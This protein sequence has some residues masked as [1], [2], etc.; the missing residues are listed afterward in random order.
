MDLSNPRKTLVRACSVVIA[1]GF[2]ASTLPLPAAAAPLDGA[3]GPMAALQDPT[4]DGPGAGEHGE[5]TTSY[6]P[7]LDESTDRIIVKFEDDAAP[8]QRDAVVAEVAADDGVSAESLEPL[9]ETVGGALVLEADQML[10]ETELE[11]TIEALEADPA[12][13]YAEPDYIINA[14]QAATPRNPPNDPYY[15]GYQWN[16]RAI[17]AAGA[18]RYATGEGGGIGI[19]DT[20]Q[21][22]H[23]ELSGKTL[24]GYDF[25]SAGQSR[26]S[27]G[28]NPNPNDEGDW[29]PQVPTSMW[30][31]THVAVI[32]AA[33]TDNGTGVAGVAPTREC[34]TL[35]LWVLMVGLIPLIRQPVLPGAPVCQCPVL[36]PTPLLRRSATT[37]RIFI[38]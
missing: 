8:V 25:V 21:T 14:P 23:P 2:L 31:G 26:D 17:D 10:G 5:A 19:A 16:M 32:A 22:G 35:G 11:Q 3:A 1:T 30:H 37:Q 34:S 4:A 29:G 6:A 15:A 33:Y 18:W 28:W 7:S 9:K 13:E 20:A 38:R 36:P 12:V 24:A 27:N